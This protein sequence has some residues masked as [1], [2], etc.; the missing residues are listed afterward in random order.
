M[1]RHLVRQKFFFLIPELYQLKGKIQRFS[2]SRRVF[3]GSQGP[4]AAIVSSRSLN[5]W[6]HPHL[7]ED[8]CTTLWEAGSRRYP[9]IYVA[10]LYLD[11][12]AEN[13]M[14]FP[15]SWK[16]L[17]DYC[18]RTNSPLIAGTDT[19]ADSTLW[20]EKT[21]KRGEVVEEFIFTKSLTL[22]NLGTSP[23][24]VARGTHVCIDITVSMNLTP[25][26]IETWRVSNE[27][28]LSDHRPITFQITLGH[29]TPKHKIQNPEKTTWTTFRNRL[30]E[31][32]ILRPIYITANWLDAKA[33]WL[34]R[35]ICT[36]LDDACPPRWVTQAPRRPKY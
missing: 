34:E 21:N 16:K 24:F 25:D 9:R 31:A 3:S 29:G 18:A 26:F 27:V 12:T 36:A 7:T 1:T 15:N 32:P 30:D 20:G 19:N 11:I 2:D 22:H 5:V 4:R 23:T 28:T 17:V 8:L 35:N 13:G 10:S 33:N 6:H 14:L